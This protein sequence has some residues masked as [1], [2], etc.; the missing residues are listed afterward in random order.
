[1]T[2]TIE[3]AQKLIQI[4]SVTPNDKGVRTLLLTTSNH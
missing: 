2:E 4:D 1:M 3:L